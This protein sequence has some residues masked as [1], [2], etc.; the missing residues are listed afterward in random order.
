MKSSSLA[1]LAALLLPLAAPAADDDLLV[2]VFVTGVG[3]TQEAAM[4][5]ALI[6][7]SKIVGTPKSADG[8]FTE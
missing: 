4:K 2:E 3:T 6:A 5:A 1:A 7:N 8:Q